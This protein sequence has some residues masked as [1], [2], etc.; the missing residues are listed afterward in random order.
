MSGYHRRKQSH[1]ASEREI[2]KRAVQQCQLF[3]ILHENKG[4]GK[5]WKSEVIRCLWENSFSWVVGV[6]SKSEWWRKAGS[7]WR[8]PPAPAHPPPLPSPPPPPPS[9]FLDKFYRKWEKE[10]RMILWKH[11]KCLQEQLLAFPLCEYMA[12]ECSHAQLRANGILTI[13]LA[14]GLYSC[15]W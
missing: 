1:K 14:K 3:H 5:A 2:N 10:D 11:R 13:H 8:L 7:A 15:L 6:E 12:S 9:S 4:W